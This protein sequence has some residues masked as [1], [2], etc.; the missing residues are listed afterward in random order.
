MRINTYICFILGLIFISLSTET[1]AQYSSIQNRFEVDFIKGCVGWEVNV[2]IND[3]GGVFENPRFWYTGFNDDEPANAS[4]SH[5]YTEAGTFYIAMLINPTNGFEDNQLDSIQVEV[6]ESRDPSFIIRNCDANRVRVQITDD[7]YDRY[8]V[9]F[10][11]TDSEIVQPMDTSGIFDYGTVGDYRIEV[12]G[13]FVDAAPNCA[14]VNEG[15]TSIDEIIEPLITSLETTDNDRVTGELQM[16]HTLGDHSIYHLLESVESSTSFDSLFSVSGAETLITDHN[17][18]DSYSCYQ[19][20]TYDA[21][22]ELIISSNILC[23]VNFHIETSDDGNLL[24]W[25]TDETQANSYNLIRNNSL[26]INIA[27]PTVKLYNDT[28]VI[29]REE[30]VY[31]V[32]A[33]FGTESS[34][35]KDTA[36][37]ASRSGE[38]PPITDYP[39]STFNTSNEIVL[40]WSPPQ[41]ELIPF[42]RYIVQKRTNNRTWRYVDTTEDTTFIDSNPDLI[43]L[44]SYRITYDDQCGNQATPSPVTQ[45]MLLSQLSSRGQSVSYSWNKYETWQEG[46]R[47]YTLE[48]V[49]ASGNVIS[50]YSV[51]SGR[52][53]EIEYGINDLDEKLVRVRA[54]SL[55]QT[56]LVSYS[57]IIESRLSFRMFL[58]NAFTPDG[59]NLNDN[60]I[61]EGPAV[62]NFK[63]E[64]YNRWGERVFST[65]DLINGWDGNINGDKAPQATY[66][67][68]IFFEDASG[69]K[70]DQMGSFILLRH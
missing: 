13:Q 32:Q 8:Q 60:F 42:R 70:Y 52:E 55:G 59:D 18:L 1:L 56:A 7:F 3:P 61:A 14:T 65:N 33:L 57:N 11:T 36:I 69:R 29:C 54:E 23:S 15:F 34:L 41:A 46:I 62:F 24:T 27:D 53:A 66:I 26:L 17:T 64:V 50:E 25:D 22:N 28:A 38:L 16:A 48:R 37:I 21:C 10:T 19:I 63:M 68:K 67:Y 2:T 44:Q 9:N 40:N 5:I 20:Q 39:S 31:N 43:G 4:L 12:Q 35:A 6:L 47:N 58:P 30:Y 51:L 49:D 45:P